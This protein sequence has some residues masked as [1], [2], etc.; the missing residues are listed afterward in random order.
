M[1]ATLVAAG[2]G[3]GLLA[4]MLGAVA[5]AA[6]AD[7]ADTTASDAGR[8]RFLA[9]AGVGGAVAVGAGVVGRRVLGSVP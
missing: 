8:R 6:E 3:S 9:L 1:A 4:A 5:R 7:P 2:A